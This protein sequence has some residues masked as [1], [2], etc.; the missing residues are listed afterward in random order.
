[1]QFAPF[2]GSVLAVAPLVAQMGQAYPE[3]AAK[4]TLVEQVLAAEE[5]RFAETLDS[6]MK[7]F[8]QIVLKTG[9]VIPGAVSRS[10]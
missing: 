10:T 6:G 8:E 9:G 5:E 7:V 3:L 4:A 2:V 1:M